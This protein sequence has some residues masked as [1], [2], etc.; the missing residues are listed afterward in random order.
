MSSRAVD[1][2]AAA[3][4]LG[5]PRRVGLARAPR[6]GPRETPPCSCAAARAARSRLVWLG[7]HGSWSGARAAVA[8]VARAV[9]QAL[10][11]VV[12]VVDR[13]AVALVPLD[14]RAR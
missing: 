6:P 3:A 13:A 5:A 14:V 2:A 12:V 7:A 9:V 1:A 10:G 4:A 8:A 11:L